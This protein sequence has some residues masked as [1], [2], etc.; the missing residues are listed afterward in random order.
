MNKPYSLKDGP[1]NIPGIPTSTPPSIFPCNNEP[2][3]LDI[4]IAIRKGV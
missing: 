2:I 1:E 3:D 4:P